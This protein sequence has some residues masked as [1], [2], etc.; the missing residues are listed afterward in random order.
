MTKG[1][2]FSLSS[3]FSTEIG[4]LRV[5]CLRVCASVYSQKDFKYLYW[6]NFLKRQV[7]DPCLMIKC[8]RKTL[9]S[10]KGINGLYEVSGSLN[11]NLW[12]STQNSGLVSFSPPFLTNSLNDIL[13]SQMIIKSRYKSY[14]IYKTYQNESAIYELAHRTW[15]NIKCNLLLKLTLNICFSRE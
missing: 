14:F 6:K 10:S 8:V 1:W 15:T 5:V 4:F 12:F 2:L 11:L 9:T 3:F 7:S 13:Y